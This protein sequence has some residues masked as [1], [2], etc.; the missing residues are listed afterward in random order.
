MTRVLVSLKAACKSALG[1][2]IEK[3]AVDRW[4][5]LES[6]IAV[7][8]LLV[9]VELT[10]LGE[11]LSDVELLPVVVTEMLFRGVKFTGTFNPV[12]ASAVVS[13]RENT[14]LASSTRMSTTTSARGLSR[15]RIIFS[16]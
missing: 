11:L 7:P 9:A 3:S 10:L 6:G 1:S 2:T 12:E 4:L 8:L 5:R 14:E 15:S 16:A 13:W